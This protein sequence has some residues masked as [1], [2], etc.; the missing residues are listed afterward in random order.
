MYDHQIFFIDKPLHWSSFDVVK[1]LRGLL[2]VKKIGHAGTL[3]PLATGL[4]IVGT[5]KKTKELG[6]YQLMPKQY[7]GIIDIGKTTPSH[8]LGTSFDSTLG[9]DGIQEEQIQKALQIL[10][11]S[12]NQ[13]PPLYSAIKLKGKRAYEFARKGKSITLAPRKVVVYS[14]IATQI[15]LPSIHFRIT[16]SKGTYIRSLARDLGKQLGTGAFLRSL[17]RT[18]IGDISIANAYTIEDMRNLVS[19]QVLAK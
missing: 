16:C 6:R 15:V 9:Y 1:K 5:G 4:L 7:E 8:D 3:D 11:G 12:Q 19:R 14:F 18:G 10:T 13:V 2:Q 17:I